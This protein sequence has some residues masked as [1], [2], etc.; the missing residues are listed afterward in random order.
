MKKLLAFVLVL[1]CVLC[2]T[3]VGCAAPQP[4]M[5]L[6]V[7]IEAEGYDTFRPW[8]ESFLKKN[9]NIEIDFIKIPKASTNPSENQNEIR[10]QFL[11]QLRGARFGRCPN[12][13]F[14]KKME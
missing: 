4:T 11:A 7:C 5:V 9:K 13:P 2:C 3:M 10:Q 8:L 12:P 6:S 1:C 14:F